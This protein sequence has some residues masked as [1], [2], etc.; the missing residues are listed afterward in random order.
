[1]STIEKY[2][3]QCV[4]ELIDKCSRAISEFTQDITEI[5]KVEGEQRLPDWE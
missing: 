2:N 5:R 4:N 1:M 3:T